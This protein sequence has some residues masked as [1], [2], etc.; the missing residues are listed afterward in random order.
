MFVRISMGRPSGKALLRCARAG[1]AKKAKGPTGF[2]GMEGLGKGSPAEVVK[3]TSYVLKD[4][5]LQTQVA[6]LFQSTLEAS[7]VSL[8]PEDAGLR[9]EAEEAQARI[10]QRL[11]EVYQ[12]NPDSFEKLLSL[13]S[14]EESDK[15]TTKETD[16]F[17]EGSIPGTRNPPWAGST[18]W[19]T[20]FDDLKQEALADESAQAEKM[21]E[22]QFDEEVARLEENEPQVMDPV[23]VLAGSDVEDVQ[24]KNEFEDHFQVEGLDS[25]TSGRKCRGTCL[26]CS[27]YRQQ[28]PLEPMNVHL[29]KSFMTSAGFIKSR[30]QTGL[31]KKMQGRV[32]KTIKH[33]RALGLFSYKG[34]SF[35][36][37]NPVM[38]PEDEY[39]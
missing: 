5:Q 18:V 26:F 28:Y 3:N 15:A 22:A 35:T 4:I 11:E 8:H 6:R 10:M 36:I 30:R 12:N 39:F 16:K 31:C 37:R 34:G 7:G 32:A 25:P 38:C 20:F 23:E 19:K 21:T 1:Y 2:E 29:L 33:A 17:L 9:S 27:P 14:Q 24:I 13:I